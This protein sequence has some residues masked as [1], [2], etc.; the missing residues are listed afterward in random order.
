[1][2]KSFLERL[3]NFSLLGSLTWLSTSSILNSVNWPRRMRL[4]PTINPKAFPSATA[5]AT[6]SFRGKM[7]TWATITP[8]FC[9]SVK[10]EWVF[11][12]SVKTNQLCPQSAQQACPKW[13]IFFFLYD[14]HDNEKTCRGRKLS[15]EAPLGSVEGYHH[16]SGQERAHWKRLRGPS[17]S[18]GRI[19]GS[20]WINAQRLQATLGLFCFSVFIQPC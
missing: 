5:S 19:F 14:F 2:P 20:W 7:S 11:S 1:M 18:T 8:T 12:K 15:F 16:I 17:R 9:S 6:T 3:T 4:T 13:S 10:A